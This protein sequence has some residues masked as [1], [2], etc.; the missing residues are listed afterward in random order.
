MR[1]TYIA[2]AAI[3][4][5]LCASAQKVPA[6]N[7]QNPAQSAD[8]PG[9][10]LF[11]MLDAGNGLPNNNVRNALMLPSGLMCIQ[12]PTAIN[13]F[14]AVSCETFRYDFSKISYSEY[15][16]MDRIIYDPFENILWCSS[17][18]QHWI[19]DL[20]SKSLDYDIDGRLASYGLIHNSAIDNILVDAEQRLWVVYTDGYIHICDRQ[21]KQR[22]TTALPSG[23]QTPVILKESGESLWFL[24]VN[25]IL[26]LYDKTS[27]SFSDIQ[28][29]PLSTSAASR[30]NLE[31]STKPGSDTRSSG[32]NPANDTVTRNSSVNAEAG[33]KP[34]ASGSQSS[35]SIWAMY[36]NELF[37]Y[38]PQSK[39][40]EKI[41]LIRLGDKDLFTSICI[42]KEQKLWIGTARSGLSI[43]DLSTRELERLPYI[44]LIDSRKIYPHTDINKIYCDHR[45]TIWIATQAEGLAYWCKDAFYIESI[46]SASLKRGSFPDEGVKC[47][48][49]D[50]DGSIL[51]GTVNGFLRYDPQTN[52]L[53]LP[54]HELRNELCISLYRDSR[55]R[56]WLGTFY[57][58]VYCIDKG[59][60][61]H[62]NYPEMGSVDVSYQEERPNFN[63]VRQMAEDP[64]G[65]FWISV[66]GG[67][68]IFDPSTGTI[69][70][71]RD[72]H[73]ELS[74]YMIIRDLELIGTE[75]LYACGDN[76]SF[77]YDIAS[78]S[79]LASSN[80]VSYQSLQDSRGQIWYAGEDGLKLSS[81]DIFHKIQGEAGNHTTPN[82]DSAARANPSPGGIPGKPQTILESSISNIC[83]DSYGDIW[84]SSTYSIYRIRP[85]LSVFAYSKSDGVD[86]GAFFQNSNLIHS[87]GEIYLGGSSGIAKIDPSR[88]QIRNYDI[89]PYI[90]S[91]SVGGKPTQVK[92]K[93]T[94]RHDESSI[95]ISFSNLNYA[96]PSHSSYRYMLSNFDKGWQFVQGQGSA[97][98]KY[99]YLPAGDYMLQIYGS[100]NGSGWNS[101][102]T[103]IEISVLPP[104]Y[105][106]STAK[107]IYIFLGLVAFFFIV[108]FAIRKTKQRSERDNARRLDQMKMRF[109]T[110]IS[111][112]LR[113]P[114]SLI[115]L[116]ISKLL[117]EESDPEHKA[118][119]ETMRS[120]A[121]ELL[122]LVN[123]LLDFRRLEL[124]GETL[125]LSQGNI[126]EFIFG[127]LESFRELAER[128][129]ISL[130]FEDSMPNPIMSFDSGKM[131]KIVSNLLSNAL[132][133]TPKGGFIELSLSQKDEMF[134]LD[135]IDS[136]TG[137]AEDELDKIFDRFYR[138]QGSELISGSGIGLS[139]VKQY[140]EM[141]KGGIEVES[142]LGKGT[143]F[144]ISIPRNLK[145][146]DS[147]AEAEVIVNY[148]EPKSGTEAEESP[149]K[150]LMI[151]DDNAEFNKYLCTELEKQ[152]KVCSAKDGESCLKKVKKEMPDVIVSDVMMPNIDGFALTKA[153]KSD[154]ETSH[155]PVILLTAHFSDDNRLEGYET[156]A[157]AFLSKPFKMEILE[158]RIHNL[159]SDRQK[160]MSRLTKEKEF[161][162]ERTAIATI[163]QKF[164]A[165]VMKSIERNMDNIEYSVEELASDVGMHRMNI[166][167]KLQALTGMT[168]SVF[169]RTMRLKKAAQLLVDDPGL[170]VSEVAMMTGFNTLKYFTKYF[171]EQFGVTPSKYNKQ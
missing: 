2:L 9:Q 151:V 63:C 146:E 112:E 80:E 3:L 105:S 36:D 82:T 32:A 95:A 143:I 126:S 79:I 64:E 113:T 19:F 16:G 139:L 140:V 13:L 76:G 145:A 109:F 125:H 121:T 116:P 44:E 89:P 77:S 54:Y 124:K 5:Y 134:C 42:D 117:K 170:N 128:K 98:A 50:S 162:P 67:V 168:P 71:L 7:I 62:F 86:A 115:L 10:R 57:N 136:G 106:S 38:K 93:L 4:L 41:E 61:K 135:V 141:H 47:M 68:G 22:Y 167:R 153:L 144:H 78:D 110:N 12:T 15:S 142:E 147:E 158:A 46:N 165:S 160:W 107:I 163:D 56:I 8:T 31:I 23:M 157:D 43:F 66:Y 81:N 34:A 138:A 149:R 104:F 29:L 45:G 20:G 150:K 75:V 159:I 87:S 102:P 59:R 58:G 133:F 39:E 69:S 100:Y 84:A 119:L 33:S 35:T 53:T 49:E 108:N 55:D 72:R 155:I 94:L 123:H 169:I 148:D 99:T 101:E 91:L 114:L 11:R 37:E 164:M 161:E 85:D 28:K 17:T 111:H 25:G 120:N 60:I 166:Y 88:H 48:V 27:G 137:I 65:R 129:G 131:S 154:I 122:N 156:G 73:P 96:N 97:S 14:N 130:A 74:R 118:Q 26:A 132:K 152:F 52:E 103:E 1:R 18:N 83:E 6:A 24:S 92:D 21:S 171:K 51:V 127:I 40:C 90:Y 30:M 70:L